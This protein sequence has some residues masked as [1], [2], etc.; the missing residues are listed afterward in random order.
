MFLHY[1]PAIQYVWWKPQHLDSDLCHQ[2]A[3]SDAAHE[4]RSSSFYGCGG[5]EA[6]TARRLLLPP[7][8]SVL[9]CGCGR[10]R[11]LKIGISLVLWLC[12]PPLHSPAT[13]VWR[14]EIELW[15]VPRRNQETAV[16]VVYLHAN[17]RETIFLHHLRYKC[18]IIYF[19]TNTHT[20]CGSCCVVGCRLLWKA[21]P[22]FLCIALWNSLCQNRHT[23]ILQSFI[24]IKRP[25]EN[26]LSRNT[27]S[28]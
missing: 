5:A 28:L 12:Q 1:F 18:M 14:Q 23:M 3:Q 24:L 10:W 8:R 6:C 15:D 13:V 7:L 17:Q 4:Y 25:I 19:E 2:R 9:L 26:T 11:C 27:W 16:I 22:L 20:A 21:L